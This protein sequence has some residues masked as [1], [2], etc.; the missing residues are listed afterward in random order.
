MRRVATAALVVLFSCSFA[1]ARTLDQVPPYLEKEGKFVSYP[2]LAVG[3]LGAFVGAVVSLPAVVVAA[4]VGW[5]AGDPLGYSLVPV[6]VVA[7]GGAEAGY[8]LGGAIPWVV[9]NAFYDAPMKV[10]ARIKGEPASGLVAQV[11]PAPANRGDTQYLET[12]PP[13]ARVPVVI[14]QQYSS[15]LPP[16]KPPTSLMLRRQLSPFKAP[17][18]PVKGAPARKASPSPVPPVAT[19]ARPLPPPV[20][21]AA[22]VVRPPAP[23]AEPVWS[24]PPP[25]VVTP[26]PPPAVVVPEPA[27]VPPPAV[28]SPVVVDAPPSASPPPAVE[29]VASRYAQEP[30]AAS[31]PVVGAPIQVDA[32]PGTESMPAAAPVPVV[33]DIVVEGEADAGQRPALKKKKRKFS[34]RFGF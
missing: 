30:F 10:V 19:A 9:K 3:G 14:A 33:E 2:A 21:P 24:P 13:A 32:A 6:S 20:M 7:T 1:Q 12:T 18:L 17:P 25:A 28:M 16:P 8:H 22:E 27:V 4:P 15:A 34:E 5:A 11:E 29:E 23:P 26:P 31:P